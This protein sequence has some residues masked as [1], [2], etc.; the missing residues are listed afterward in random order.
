MRKSHSVLNGL[1]AARANSEASRRRQAESNRGASS[2]N[3]LS[4]DQRFECDAGIRILMNSVPGI[5]ARWLRSQPRLSLNHPSENVDRAKIRA[6][7]DFKHSHHTEHRIPRGNDGA[8][9]EFHLGTNSLQFRADWPKLTDHRQRIGVTDV[10]QNVQMAQHK[11]G[12][13]SASENGRSLPRTSRGGYR[14]CESALWRHQS[15]KSP[16]RSSSKIQEFKITCADRVGAVPQFAGD[17]GQSFLMVAIRNLYW[18]EARA[19]FIVGG[20]ILASTLCGGR[21]RGAGEYPRRRS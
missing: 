19:A 20:L 3:E 11:L 1:G 12:L 21:R 6:G 17:P 15:C 9:P 13:L 8:Q 14:W 18:T 4:T 2:S 7:S 16:A 5:V 10:Q